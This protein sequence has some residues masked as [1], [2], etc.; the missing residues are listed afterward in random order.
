MLLIGKILNL[1]LKKMLRKTFIYENC[2]E[3]I[4]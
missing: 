3:Y 1:Y 4:E 2:Y